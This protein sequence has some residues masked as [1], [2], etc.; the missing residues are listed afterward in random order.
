MMP[1]KRARPPSQAKSFT[2]MKASSV[3]GGRRG[4]S[5]GLTGGVAAGVVRAAICGETGGVTWRET[6]EGT[7]LDEEV[8]SGADHAAMEGRGGGVD[9]GCSTDGTAGAGVIGVLAAGNGDTSGDGVF[10]V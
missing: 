5:T 9:S 2:P 8:G 4:F 1:R 3:I 6:G 10:C 7:G